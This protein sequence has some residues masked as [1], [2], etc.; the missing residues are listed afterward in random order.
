[1]SKL[2]LADD[3]YLRAIVVSGQDHLNSININ[4]SKNKRTNPSQ[5]QT[6]KQF[7]NTAYNM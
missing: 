1:M 5:S 3:E 2:S 4:V 7:V 6:S